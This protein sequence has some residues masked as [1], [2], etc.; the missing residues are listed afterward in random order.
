MS[1]IVVVATLAGTLSSCSASPPAA[2]VNGQV[3]TQGQLDQWL[4]EWSSSPAYVKAFEEASAV[5]SQEAASQGQQQ[6]TFS[7][8]GTGSGPGDY[9]LVWT[10]GRLTLLVS[11]S[12]VHQYLQRRGEAPSALEVAAAWASQYA[13]NP[14]E[15]E[16]LPA[17]L[18]SEVADQDAEHALIEPKSSNLAGDKEL[19][20]DESSYFWA[21]VCLR[22]VDVTVAGPGESVDVAASRKQADEI[23]G[24]LERHAAAV[25]GASGDQRGALLLDS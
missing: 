5:E 14:P 10:T 18:R 13:A 7:V 19:Y 12:A 25:L 17:A 2:S 16:Q 23:A 3:I 21:S 1:A 20:K 4:D 11:A 22:T 24:E 6:P 15:W 9:G 8:Q